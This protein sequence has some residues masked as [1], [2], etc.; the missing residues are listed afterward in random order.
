M[1]LVIVARISI[2]KDAIFKTLYR[3]LLLDSG[4][5]ALKGFISW[6]VAIKMHWETLSCRALTSDKLVMLN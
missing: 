2:I 1:N 5:R 6:F 4:Q 3:I